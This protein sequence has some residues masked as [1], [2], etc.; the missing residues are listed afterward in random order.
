LSPHAIT[1]VEQHKSSTTGGEV[2]HQI[3][4]GRTG[5][6]AGVVAAAA[7]AVAGIAVTAAP[8]GAAPVRAALTGD[9]AAV[10]TQVPDTIQ[11]PVGNKRI[12]EMDARGVQTYQCTNGVFTFQQ[13]DAILTSNGKPQILHTRGPIWTSV[14]DGSTVG[15]TTVATAPSPNS[16]AQL[17]LAGNKVRGPGLLA[18]VTFI[19]RLDTTGGLAPTGACVEGTTASVPYTATYTFWVKA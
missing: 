3:R 8:A 1:V 2:T 14:V 12:A 19:Q 13:P 9:Q 17:L 10:Q 4:F 16:I 15:G 7:F 18:D 6:I 5:R 11:P